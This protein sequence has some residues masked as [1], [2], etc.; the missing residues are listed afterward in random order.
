MK[1]ASNKLLDISL[2]FE[3]LL[4]IGSYCNSFT[5]I[6]GNNL[7]AEVGDIVSV[8]LKGRSLNGLI[9]ADKP[10]FEKNKLGREI[11]KDSN[12]KYLFIEDVVQKKVIQDW[13]RD[14]LE[15]LASF[16]RVSNVKMFK[17][18]FPPGW[19]G[20]QKNKSHGFKEQIWIERQKNS[21]FCKDELTKKEYLLIKTLSYQGNWQ[22]ELIKHGFSSTLINLLI[23]RNL[24]SKTK[25]KKLSNT[26]ISAF[27]SDLKEIKKPDLTTEQ[28][29]HIKRCKG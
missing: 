17:T 23:S 4:D 15:D 25:K 5:Y 19:I 7:G 29:R 12:R 14:W 13:W 1:P 21:N 8:S 28:K 27:E 16:Y 10:L 18:A 3:V 20:K 9:I 11:E 6:D 2:K 24:L 26:K 22:S